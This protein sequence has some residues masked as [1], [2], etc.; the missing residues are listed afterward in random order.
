LAAEV[1]C[2]DAEGDAVAVND[3]NREGNRFGERFGEREAS[4]ELGVALAVD[5]EGSEDGAR[6]G[7]GGLRLG[8]DHL[9]NRELEV[10]GAMEGFI[11]CFVASDGDI[12][13]QVEGAAEIGAPAV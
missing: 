10:I 11:P 9:G 8:E 3:W 7:L 13:G 1:P 5:G 2:G 6:G 12:G 4:L